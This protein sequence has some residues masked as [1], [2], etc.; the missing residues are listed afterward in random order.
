[1]RGPHAYAKRTQGPPARARYNRPTRERFA[2]RRSGPGLATFTT[3]QSAAKGNHSC[4][5]APTVADYTSRLSSPRLLLVT[6]IPDVPSCSAAN[7][8]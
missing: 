4:A 7:S 8:I 1:M 3:V 2:S 6:R 5:N